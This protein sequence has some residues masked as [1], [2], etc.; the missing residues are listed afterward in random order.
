[1]TLVIAVLL[2]AQLGVSNPFAYVFVLFVW[3]AHL[4]WGAMR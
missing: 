1:M 2:L 4:V 3:L